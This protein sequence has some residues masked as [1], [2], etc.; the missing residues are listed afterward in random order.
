MQRVCRL[1]WTA[2]AGER[3]DRDLGDGYRIRFSLPSQIPVDGPVLQG[4]EVLQSVGRDEIAVFQADLQ[5]LANVP[6]ILGLTPVDAQDE[7]L[8]LILTLAPWL[9]N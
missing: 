3:V 9:E 8:W 1:E 6:L 2:T 7:Q 5:P 4:F